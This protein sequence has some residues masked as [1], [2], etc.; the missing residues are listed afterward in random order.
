MSTMPPYALAAFPPHHWG[1]LHAQR[2]QRDTPTGAIQ[3]HI[4]HT[5]SPGAEA[6]TQAPVS[7]GVNYV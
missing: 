3:A 6:I 1:N 2:A 4:E 7:P 5:P